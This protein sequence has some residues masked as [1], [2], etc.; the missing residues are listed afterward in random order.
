MALKCFLATG[1]RLQILPIYLPILNYAPEGETY[2]E[3][4]AARWAQAKRHALG[5]AELVYFL[6]H[7]IRILGCVGKGRD[8]ITFVYRSLFLW[9]N[10]LMTHLVLAT[11]LVLAPFNCLVIGWFV[12]SEGQ[13]SSLEISA[14][15][16]NVVSQA[17]ICLSFVGVCAASAIL[18]DCIKDRVRGAE[19]PA[20]GI[21]WRSTL[22]NSLVTTLEIG[23]WM[24][25]FF[26]VAMAVEWIA[27][28]KSAH[29]HRF[30]YEV[31][32]KPNLSK[33][34]LE[35]KSDS[36]GSGMDS[37]SEPEEPSDSA[38]GDSL[39]ASRADSAS[40]LEEDD[41]AQQ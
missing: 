7:F 20:L 34:S 21:R 39:P 8:Q 4:Q 35:S 10:C 26:T 11:F 27:A 13:H 14:F 23:P 17:V 37:A 40:E 6:D 15:V 36:T 19:D 25:L 9:G 28:L 3:T 5:F 1:G 24:P 33:D 30:D 29:T 16:A 18:Y 41:S 32:L 12:K 22:V 31:A 38:G 2:T